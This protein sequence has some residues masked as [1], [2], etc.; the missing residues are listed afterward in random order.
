VGEKFVDEDSVGEKPV[1][2]KRVGEKSVGDVFLSL[3]V[4]YYSSFFP[5][6]ISH[7]RGWSWFSLHPSQVLEMD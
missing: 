7:H 6:F 2:E 4:C 5:L 3:L 1:S